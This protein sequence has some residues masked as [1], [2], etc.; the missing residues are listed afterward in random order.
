MGVEVASDLPK[1]NGEAK[2]ELQYNK[3]GEINGSEP[4]MLGRHRV[5]DQEA[6]VPKD[7][8]EEWPEPQVYEDPYLKAKIEQSDREIQTINR[9]TSQNIDSLKPQ[10]SERAELVATLKSLD[11][12]SSKSW[13]I[14]NEKRQEMRLSRMLWEACVVLAEDLACAHLKKNLMS[15]SNL[16][17]KILIL[18]FFLLLGTNLDGI[19]KQREEIKAKMD[20]L[21]QQLG[22]LNIQIDAQQQD[23]EALNK[24]RDEAI[25]IIKDMRQKREEGNT[26]AYENQAVINTAKELAAKKDV[27]TLEEFVDAEVE[28]F[29]SNW[30]SSKAFR[31]AYQKI[32]L[33]SLDIQ[34]RD[35]RMRSPDQKPLITVQAP[36]PGKLVVPKATPI[37]HKEDPQIKI[38]K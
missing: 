16:L 21:G 13:A 34:S 37:A 2:S 7:V 20:Q 10:Q 36:R 35:G 26:C 5:T 18:T 31:N 3:D 30:N 25:A 23:L 6:H 27:R 1:V 15:Y 29:M 19:R 11:A 22:A 17:F 38:P 4:I 33:A 8:V 9:R 24:K 12:E 32:I 28:R 14:I